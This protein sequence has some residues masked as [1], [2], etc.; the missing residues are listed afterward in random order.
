MSKLLVWETIQLPLCAEQ[1]EEKAKK[2]ELRLGK[3]FA[4]SPSMTAKLACTSGT[5]PPQ[6]ATSMVVPA[7]GPA[8]GTLLRI[9]QASSDAHN[10]R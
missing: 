3:T 5:A 7:I 4:K 6:A 2:V 10:L 1:E 9:C 8:L